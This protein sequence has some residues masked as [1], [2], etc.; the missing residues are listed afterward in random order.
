VE[1]DDRDWRPIAAASLVVL[2]LT[3]IGVIVGLIILGK[4]DDAVQDSITGLA[5]IGAGLTGGFAGW[6]AR[7]VSHNDEN[8]SNAPTHTQPSHPPTP[9]DDP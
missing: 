7:G 6:F 4:R 9:G 5:T 3:L 1:H 8:K 2:G